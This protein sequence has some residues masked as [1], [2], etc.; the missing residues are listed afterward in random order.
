MVLGEH[1]ARGRSAL[2][3]EWFEMLEAP[4]KEL[5]T[6]ADSGHRAHFDRPAQFAAVMDR[7]LGYVRATTTD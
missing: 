2:A 5:I 1:E 4:S 3:Q 6:F 7:V